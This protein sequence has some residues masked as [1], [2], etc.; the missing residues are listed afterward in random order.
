M[1]IQVPYTLLRNRTFSYNRKINSSI[2]RVSL[3]TKEEATALHLVTHINQLVDQLLSN[4]TP[5]DQIRIAV[6]EWLNTKPTTSQTNSP[7]K[8]E[9]SIVIQGTTPTITPEAEPLDAPKT[10]KKLSE[11]RDLFEEERRREKKQ[12][13]SKT[14][15]YYRNSINTFIELVSDIHIEDLNKETVRL[16]K[17]GLSEYPAS[18]NLHNNKN[19]SLKELRRRGLPLLSQQSINQHYQRISSFMHWCVNHDYLSK[20][21][22]PALAPPKIKNNK[23]APFTRNDIQN[24]FSQPVFTEHNHLKDRPTDYW[25]PILGLYTGARLNELAQLKKEHIIKVDGVDVISLK[26]DGMKLKNEESARYIPIHNELIQLGFLRFVSTSA[27]GHLFKDLSET[28]AAKERGEYGA[29]YNK[30]FTRLKQALG[31]DQNKSYHSFRHTMADELKEAKVP[32]EHIQA[33][34]GHTPE[35]I[36]QRVYMTEYPAME[37]K[38][39]LDQVSFTNE[40]KDLAFG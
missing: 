30:R 26:E 22:L 28:V 15:D 20:N 23:R 27:S 16:F 7:A 6:K 3:G 37:L 39:Q 4:R 32:L 38:V 10:S 33:I 13:N 34:L 14:H 5:F 12:L 1:C 29:A 8:P 9:N 21:P 31:F 25:L 18:R 35:T 24:I 11:L 17:A 19:K 40:L 36:T 2:L